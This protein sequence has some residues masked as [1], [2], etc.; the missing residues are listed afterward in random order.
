M[1]KTFQHKLEF[2]IVKTLSF[3]LNLMPL[4]IALRL[5]DLIGFISFSILRIRRKVSL[6]NLKRSFG[7]KYTDK[8]YRR[9]AL[10]SYINFARDMIEFG[11]FPKIAKMNLDDIMKFGD[12]SHITDHFKSGGGAVMFSGHFGNFELWGACFKYFNWPVDILVGKQRNPMV[13]SLM[14]HYRSLFGAKLIEI[15]VSARE[16]FRSL[17]EGR[18]VAM[19]SDQDAGSDGVIVNFLGRPASTP[20]G[21]AAFALKSRCPIFVGM[22]VREGLAGHRAIFEEPV[23][24]V[25]TGNKDEDIKSLTQAYTDVLARYVALYPDHY[26]WAHRRWKSTC[27]D[28]YE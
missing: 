1:T 4:K 16:V 15:G 17:K 8:E 9:I 10:R 26:F 20:K 11:L 23:T 19:L 12:C 27:P 14:N 7:D 18:G 28:D 24:I 21:P 3:L 25:P 5:G 22:M 6:T 2:A 13:N